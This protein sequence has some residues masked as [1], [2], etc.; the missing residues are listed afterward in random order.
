MLV[1]SLI[2][3]GGRSRRMGKPKESLLLGGNTL[4]GRTIEMLLEC[5]WPVIVVGRGG[6]QQLP[7]LPLEATVIADEQPGAGPLAAIATGLRHV[8]N[9]RELG[10][11]D[12]VFVTGCDSPYLTANVVGWMSEQMAQRQCVMP[13]SGGVLQPL[14]A[15]Y[16][17]DC[18][19]VIEELLRNGVETPRT[20][21][22]K[23]DTLILEDAALQK[24]DPGLRF[25]KSLNTPEDY[26][27]AQRDFGT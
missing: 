14:C 10:D 23:V 11:K 15:L 22:E 3:A 7:P 1:G 19:P 8:R 26:A 13:R 24:C 21:A 4:L 2:L 25:L 12:A 6:D 9:S 17:L 18:L 5:T 20:L 16:R 27:Q